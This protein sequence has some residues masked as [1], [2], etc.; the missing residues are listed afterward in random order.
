M[1][2]VVAAEMRELDR[3]AT[4]EFGV[5]SLLLMENAG[6]AVARSAQHMLAFPEPAIQDPRIVVVAGRGN[7]GGDGLVAARHLHA[8]GWDVH[9]TLA[10]PE[11]R[12]QGEARANLEMVQ[13]AGVPL[14][15][16]EAAPERFNADLIIDALLGT[17]LKGDPTG[18][19]AALVEAINR[20][21]APVL[22]VDVP[23]GLNADT[24]RAAVCVRAVRTV[25]F[26]LPKVG[27]LFYPG[28]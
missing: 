12:V 22:A 2:A 6:A 25:T 14:A 1:R 27:L 28:R 5:P 3:R 8:A 19:S 26:A 21:G 4:D 9:I 7:N 15:V 18:L 13:R 17:G 10:G 11:E 16:V 23:S 24:G 20:S